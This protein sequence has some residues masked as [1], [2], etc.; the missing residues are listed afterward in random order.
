MPYSKDL[1][2][3]ADLDLKVQ[4][5]KVPLKWP[6]KGAAGFMK[7]KAILTQWGGENSLPALEIER[8]SGERKG[9]IV[10]HQLCA[11]K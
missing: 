5:E 9:L 3:F 8:R 11:K 1:R 10:Y 2:A 4:D 7:A 6:K